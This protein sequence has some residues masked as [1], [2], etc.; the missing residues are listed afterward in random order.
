MNI[1]KIVADAILEEIMLCGVVSKTS[2][3][4]LKKKG[5][6]YYAELDS[7]TTIV[8]GEIESNYKGCADY[9]VYELVK[10]FYNEVP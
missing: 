1:E 2:K 9:K 8:E 10:D 7:D 3:P 6:S 4:I 5:S